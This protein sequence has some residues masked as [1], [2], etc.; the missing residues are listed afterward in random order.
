M[1]AVMTHVRSAAFV[2]EPSSRKMFTTFT[3]QFMHYFRQC[4][5]YNV[6]LQ[7]KLF[8]Q[9]LCS[10]PVLQVENMPTFTVPNDIDEDG[11]TAVGG[12]G[13]YESTITES[14]SPWRMCF[15]NLEMKIVVEVPVDGS[16]Q[17]PMYNPVYFDYLNTYYLKY[18]SL[19]CT[20]HTSPLAHATC[21]GVEGLFKVRKHNMELSKKARLDV[22]LGEIDTFMDTQA[23]IFYDDFKFTTSRPKVPAGT[24]DEEGEW[25]RSHLC[26]EDYV[27]CKNLKRIANMY[28]SKLPRVS[29]KE[30]AR[31]IGDEYGVVLS[32]SVFSL[33]LSKKSTPADVQ[34]KNAIVS[35]VRKEI[36]EIES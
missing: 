9:Y 24:A 32:G 8:L 31:R 35:W 25:S 1:K 29:N 19:F 3:F 27:L 11:F 15:H 36:K 28:S 26:E 23:K 6:M 18:W 22:Y 12:I 2:C 14:E 5:S 30:L 13:V 21:A 10:T 16:F 33:M 4:T 17:N 34:V 20:F 7:L